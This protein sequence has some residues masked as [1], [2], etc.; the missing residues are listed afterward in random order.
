MLAV[1]GAGSRARHA[2]HAALTLTI[3]PPG[4]NG[5]VA[6]DRNTTDQAKLYDG[7]TP[8]GQRD[9]RAICAASSSPRRSRWPGKAARTERPRA[10]VTIE[11]DSLRR[12]ARHRQRTQEDVAFGAGYATAEDRGLLLALIRGPA[13]AAALDVPGIDPFGLAL[14]G[15]TFVPSAQTEAFL[16]QPDRRVLNATGAARQALRRA[17]VHGLR[18]RDQRVLQGQ[19][20]ADGAVHRERRD[21]GRGADRRPLRRGRRRRGRRTRMFLAA[22]AAP[23]RRRRRRR[24]L[25]RPARGERPRG[26]GL[27]ARQLPVRAAGVD[28]RRAASSLDDGSFAASAAPRQSPR[29]MSNALLV[30]RKPLG[31]RPSALRRRAAGRLLLPEFLIELDLHGGGIDARGAAFP[32]V[33]FVRPDRPRQ[34]LRLE[35]DVVAGRTSSTSS[36]RRSA[37]AT[38]VHYL[39][40][41]AVPRDD[42]AS[43]PGIAHGPA[44]EPDQPIVVPRDRPRAGARLRD[45]RAAE[46]VAI[47]LAALD[48][49]P[50][51]PERARVR[52]PQHRTASHPRRASCRR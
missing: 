23:A 30:G 8:L 21:R 27:G 12:P 26:A 1:A 6:F 35:R 42:D 40:K 46:R 13:R 49:R 16:A 38:T 10:G 4:E 48:A 36:S 41:G 25:R 33:P 34:G 2:D 31:D 52:G 14:S 5:S 43:T 7:L 19:R 3:L 28:A 17:I 24:R 51:A 32:G 45:G 18:R 20:P 22:L 39:Y 9:R 15:R 47:S 44:G 29:S 37:A 50:R 11:R